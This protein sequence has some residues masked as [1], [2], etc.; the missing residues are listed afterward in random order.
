[1]VLKFAE[2]SRLQIS[3]KPRSNELSSWVKCIFLK[4]GSDIQN[5]RRYCLILF[6]FTNH[7]IIQ[8]SDS[9]PIISNAVLRRYG[10][11]P[12]ISRTPPFVKARIDNESADP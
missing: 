12:E 10:S 8:T 2:V 4:V 1:M 5:L 7:T 9:H 3:R 6:F 11:V